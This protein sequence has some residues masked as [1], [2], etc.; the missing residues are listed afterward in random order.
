[1]PVRGPP[2]PQQ[3]LG[4]GSG[5]YASW[6]GWYMPTK[7]M[8]RIL[9]VLIEQDGVAGSATWPAQSLPVWV[10]NH[11]KS[12]EPRPSTRQPTVPKAV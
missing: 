11:Q 3:M 7:G 12:Y 4:A 6:N 9:V 8:V 5:T 10:N 2:A 1:M